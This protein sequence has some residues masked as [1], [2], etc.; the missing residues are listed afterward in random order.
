[1]DSKYK[2]AIE[3]LYEELDALGE[4]AKQIKGAINTLTT[5]YL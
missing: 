1:M 3:G 5:S 2:V 4:Q